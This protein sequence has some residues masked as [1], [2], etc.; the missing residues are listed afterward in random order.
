[1][2]PFRTLRLLAFGLFSLFLFSQC[3]IHRA[4]SAS[5]EE[6]IV[7]QKDSVFDHI[8]ER[9][10][11]DAD[12]LRPKGFFTPEPTLDE[13]LFS[14]VPVYYATD[15]QPTG[16]LDPYRFYSGKPD[17]AGLH[18]GKCMVTVPA[19]HELGELERPKWW[20]LEFSEDTRKHMVLKEVVIQSEADFFQELHLAGLAADK[21]EAL[22][23]IHGFN[24]SFDE[25]ALRAAQITYDVSFGGVTLLYS[26]PSKGS[27][28]KYGKDGKQNEATE[29]NLE[30]FLETL[31]RE[32]GFDKIHIVAHSMGNR[33]LTASLIDLAQ[34]SP[35]RPLFGQII[36]AAPDVDSK[37]FVQ[38]IAPLIHQ[39]AQ[40]VTLYASS[41][42]KALL[43]SEKIHKSPRAGEAGKN[44]VVVDHIE[45]ID[46]SDIDTDFLGHSYFANTWLLINDLHY[47]IDRGWVAEKRGLKETDREKQ[48]YW[49]F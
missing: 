44:L 9:R 11:A 2:S 38:D 4:V 33:A 24:V 46:A 8:Y 29:P 19:I 23:F 28:L 41:K 49:A 26:W 14:T 36:L 18:F 45:T 27:P 39:T 15:R 17:R 31:A 6:A 16:K 48:K 34:K 13:T 21:R 1:M 37:T 47:L 30:Y 43:L 32:G 12:I 35:D 7:V 40:N 25:A 20:T 42:D 10:L 5:A 22:V 3:S